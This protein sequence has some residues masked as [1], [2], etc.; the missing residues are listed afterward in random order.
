MASELAPHGIRACTVLPGEV[1]THAWADVELQR[2]YEARIAAG[3]SARPEEAAAAYLYLASDDAAE[4]SG[5]ALV[6]D[7]GMLAWE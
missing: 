6:V 4:L 5:V 2:L 1:A 7:G 3:R